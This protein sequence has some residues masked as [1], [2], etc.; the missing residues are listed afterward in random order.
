MFKG[1]TKLD[2]SASHLLREKEKKNVCFKNKG[3]SFVTSTSI[4]GE[5]YNFALSILF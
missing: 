4:K 1:N 3:K 5:E 2:Q